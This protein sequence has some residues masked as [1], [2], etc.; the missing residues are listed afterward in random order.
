[1]KKELTLER[2][3]CFYILVIIRRLDRLTPLIFMF[4]NFIT[5]N[6]CSA[7]NKIKSFDHPKFSLVLYPVSSANL[8]NIFTQVRLLIRIS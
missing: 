6:Y 8:Q 3:S 1:M 2:R 7:S 5:T 4:N